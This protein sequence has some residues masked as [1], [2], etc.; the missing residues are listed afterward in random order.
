MLCSQNTW[1]SWIFPWFWST[2]RQNWYSP[3]S[4]QVYLRFVKK[5]TCPSKKLTRDKGNLFEHPSLYRSLIGGLQY[6]TLYRPNIAF[7]VNKLS[8]FLQA[9]TDEHWK[10]CKRM[11]RY[12]KGT[13]SLG[14]PFKPTDRLIYWKV[15]QMQIRQVAWM[16]EDPPMVIAFIL[17]EI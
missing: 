10:A 8:Q 7:S 13:S 12:L 2:S 3:N 17:E 6:L 15:M 4:V 11:L 16:I 9:P 5:G 14:L 1:L